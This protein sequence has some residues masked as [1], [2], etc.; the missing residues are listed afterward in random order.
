MKACHS[1]ALSVLLLATGGST[2]WAASPVQVAGGPILL[3]IDA[4]GDGPEPDVDCTVRALFDAGNLAITKTQTNTP[5]IKGCNGGTTAG[6]L[7][8]G[9]DTSSN[10]IVTDLLSTSAPSQATPPRP[11]L[12]GLFVIPFRI[13]AYEEFPNNNPDGFPAAINTFEFEQANGTVLATGYLCDA[14]GPAVLIDFGPASLT[15]PLELYPTA[16]APTHLRI[17]NAP[18]ELGPPNAGSFDLVDIYLPL[19]D[20]SIRIGIE[21]QSPLLVDIPLDDLDPCRTKSAAPA[22]STWAMALMAGGLLAGGM[23][24]RARR[25]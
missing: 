13:D 15:V 19:Q 17:A 6:A 14:A 5:L 9:Q 23:R 10:Y 1:L 24:R 11:Q 8:S 2:A 20:G 22:L 12:A 21:G 16:A 25:R 3:L 18:Y 7:A 4:D